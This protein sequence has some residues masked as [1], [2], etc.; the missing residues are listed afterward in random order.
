MT[1]STPIHTRATWGV[2]N[3]PGLFRNA[4]VTVQ[5]GPCGAFREPEAMQPSHLVTHNGASD[6]TIGPVPGCGRQARRG[7]MNPEFPESPDSRGGSLA[8]GHPGSSVR[9]NRTGSA[10]TLAAESRSASRAASVAL[11]R[12]GGSASLNFRAA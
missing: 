12:R 1:F 3:G 4:I 7:E 8:A 6:L 9:L 10:R 11:A 2:G 5:P